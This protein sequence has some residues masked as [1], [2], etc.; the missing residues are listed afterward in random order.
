MAEVLNHGELSD[1]QRRCVDTILTSCSALGILVDGFLDFSRIEAGQL[2]LMRS[3]F[4]LQDVVDDVLDVFAHAAGAKGIEF[5]ALVD[6]D[7]PTALRG[8]PNRLRQVLIN[9]VG[10]A[11]KFTSE[12]EVVVRVT[13][14]WEESRSARVR[15]H[16][17][18][19]GIGIS[20]RAREAL[21][22]PFSGL[23]RFPGE[24]QSGLGLG[25]YIAKYLVACMGGEI[26]VESNAPTAGSSFWFTARLER[27]P[28]D[29]PDV[30]SAPDALRGVPV[31]LL[32]P[33]SPLR[34]I[35]AAQVAVCG[36]HVRVEH[37]VAVGLKELRAAAYAGKPYQILLVDS[38]VDRLEIYHLLQSG[39]KDKDLPIPKIVVL[40]AMGVGSGQI[41]K[42]L[43]HSATYLN[44]PITQSR[45]A[46]ALLLALGENQRAGI[47]RAEGSVA[48]M[49]ASRAARNDPETLNSGLDQR[50]ILLAED[51]PT[52]RQALAQLLEKMG[53]AVDLADNGVAAVNAAGEDRY[54]AILMDCNLPQMD[55][56]QA[57]VEIRRREGG[58]RHTP[59]ICLSGSSLES[60]KD[61]ID[62]GEFD[63]YLRKPAPA[64]EIWAKLDQ[65]CA[66]RKPRGEDE[67]GLASVL[68]DP[69]A[70]EGL[71]R[72]F[73]ED[74]RERM[75]V[76]QQ[77]VAEGDFRSA[78]QAAH[79][80]HGGCLMLGVSDLAE[81]CESL[82]A[83]ARRGD[84][85]SLAECLTGVKT[86]F[87][88]VEE[89]WPS[90]GA[91]PT[92]PG[93]ER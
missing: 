67:F 34:D 26:G 74:G 53:F 61:C 91:A 5:G 50:R 75:K 47:G 83:T 70:I 14:D 79:A 69:V 82:E 15:F 6:S 41:S 25:L 21:F 3:D 76:L 32:H 92:K 11:L 33:P 65:W 62:R 2:A 93:G 8:D 88:R 49:A 44:Y 73:L 4:D 1:E 45:L 19:S 89:S 58:E 86:E 46:T 24:S 51:N 16:V 22:Q 60:T 81:A 90:G 87:G 59:I 28:A 37:E 52:T 13:L 57:A 18:D 38:K 10:N 7:V 35:L 9:L 30:W 48:R 56:A 78:A 63:D 54:D 64:K 29:S 12:G 72:T 36:A 85:A 17:R 77:A 43:H 40:T 66:A 55:G 27:R 20:A 39:A 80:F 23:D 31:L 84:H 68:T 42:D 71:R